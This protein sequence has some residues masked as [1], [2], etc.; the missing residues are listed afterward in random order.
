MRPQRIRRRTNAFAESNNSDAKRDCRA[1]SG[2]KMFE[3]ERPSVTVLTLLIKDEKEI[4]FFFSFSF[5]SLNDLEEEI[6]FSP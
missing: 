3:P 2:N 4:S 5:V 6:S 1:A